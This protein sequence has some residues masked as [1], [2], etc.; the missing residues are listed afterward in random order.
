[1]RG[2]QKSDSRGTF[3]VGLMVLGVMLSAGKCADTELLDSIDEADPEVSDEGQEE[4]DDPTSDTDESSSTD[5]D[6]DK[7]FTGVDLLVVIDNSGSMAEEQ[8]LLMNGLFGLMGNLAAVL[9]EAAADNVRVGMVTSDLGLQYGDDSST[10]SISGPVDSCEDPDGEDGRLVTLR[11]GVV[12][13]RLSSDILSCTDCP[14]GIVTEGD[15]TFIDCTELDMPADGILGEDAESFVEFGAQLACTAQV[16]TDGCGIEQQL[17]A[18]IRGIRENG[19]F[20]VEDHL[21]G[22]LVVSDE[23]DCSIE[24]VDLFSTEEWQSGAA[25]MLNVA[26]NINGNGQYLIDPADYKDIL[27]NLKGAEDEVVF[28][29]IVGVPASDNTCQGTGD[30]LEGCLSHPR[31]QLE[32]A[33]FE[34]PDGYQYTHFSPACSRIE[35]DVEVT[36]AR[37]GRRYVEVAQEFGENG[38]VASICNSDFSPFMLRLA[39][40]LASRFE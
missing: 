3:I 39:Q 16:G 24:S 2:V 1:M 30:E 28:G 36:T 23:E 25:Q 18:A 6:I 14:N 19:S 27:V 29:A 15:T 26:C 4:G 38:V 34:T 9:P 22:V 5:N 7:T 11:D 33:T 35:D 17:K 8:A 20:L 37:P 12:T 21:L 32:L 13:V 10:T 40:N 31:M